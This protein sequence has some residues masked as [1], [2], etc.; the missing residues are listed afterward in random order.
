MWISCTALYSPPIEL[1]WMEVP[2]GITLQNDSVPVL[3]TGNIT[4]S[5]PAESV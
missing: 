2:T 3:E 4:V 5:G 1:N